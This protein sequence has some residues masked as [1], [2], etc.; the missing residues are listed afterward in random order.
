MPVFG[1]FALG[2]VQ[3]DGVVLVVPATVR[4]VRSGGR[5]KMEPEEAKDREKKDDKGLE[6]TKRNK[7]CRR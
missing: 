3:E 4:D 2:D 7:Q 6:K 5:E 1:T